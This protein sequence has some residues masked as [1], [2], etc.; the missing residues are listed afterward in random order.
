VDALFCAL[1]R[2]TELLDV[3]GVS[4]TLAED[5][6]PLKANLMESPD[7]KLAVPVQLVGQV[8]TQYQWPSYGLWAHEGSLRL[9]RVMRW[10]R[11]R[12]GTARLAV[13]AAPSP[14]DVAFVSGVGRRVAAG[15]A[16]TTV[17]ALGQLE[18]DF[19]KGFFALRAGQDPRLQYLQQ[20]WLYSLQRGET[21]VS[22]LQSEVL[23]RM[24][25]GLELD[26]EEGSEE[27]SWRRS[28]EDSQGLTTLEMQDLLDRVFGRLGAMTDARLSPVARDFAQKHLWYLLVCAHTNNKIERAGALRNA[29]VEDILQKRALGAYLRRLVVDGEEW[30][31]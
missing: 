24:L 15:A 4:V 6:V 23:S 9:L 22:A 21:E 18:Q 10:P 25:C 2:G 7:F 19:G 14:V 12:Q 28:P 5:L 13:A 11:P 20:L 26:L 31:A 17:P 29:L 30:E 8:S 3:V 16:S 1:L 27:P